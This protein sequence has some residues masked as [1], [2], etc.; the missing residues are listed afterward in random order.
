MP[1]LQRSM[2]VTLAGKS[3]AFLTQLKIKEQRLV[4]NMGE[5]PF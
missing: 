5:F 3:Q 2:A 1:V 4:S